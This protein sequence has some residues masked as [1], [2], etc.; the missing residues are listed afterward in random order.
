[1]KAHTERPT[2]LVVEHDPASQGSA[3]AALA[4]DERFGV[5]GGLSDRERRRLRRRSGDGS[6]A[7][8][9]PPEPC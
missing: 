3:A 2:V 4:N 5:W 8:E 9:D 6:I 7:R 1:M